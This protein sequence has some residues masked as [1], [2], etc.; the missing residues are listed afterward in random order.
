MEISGSIAH[1][2]NNPLFIINGTLYK[3][4]KQLQKEGM[5]CQVMKEGIVQIQEVTDHI[6]KI[7]KGLKIW[8]CRQKRRFLSDEN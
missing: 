6:A 5:E 2:I 8:P 3:M 7:M 4:E 1:E